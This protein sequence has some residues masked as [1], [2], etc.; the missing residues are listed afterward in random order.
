MGPSWGAACSGAASVVLAVVQMRLPLGAQVRTG[1]R[2]A[3]DR[4][5]KFRARPQ[6]YAL[7]ARSGCAFH[8]YCPFPLAGFDGVEVGG[9]P[10]TFQKGAHGGLGLRQ[11]GVARVCHAAVGPLRAQERVPS[12]TRIF[13]WISSARH[14]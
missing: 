9:K 12:S 3:M 1:L 2:V 7:P 14:G 6:L 5:E 8:D 11:I 10:H 4:V 13:S